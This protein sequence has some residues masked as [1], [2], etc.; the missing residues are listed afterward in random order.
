M[1]SQMN[2]EAGGVHVENEV[3]Q[4]TA[5]ADVVDLVA[6]PSG[7]AVYELVCRW[8]AATVF[9]YLDP[10]A[11]NPLLHDFAQAIDAV[12]FEYLRTDRAAVAE[13]DLLFD[14][15]A[16]LS[17]AAHAAEV[18]ACDQTT[19]FV[20]AQHLQEVVVLAVE[21]LIADTLSAAEV[22]ALAMALPTA[23]GA[24]AKDTVAAAVATGAD[25]AAHARDSGSMYRNDYVQ[26]GYVQDDYV[27]TTTTF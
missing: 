18:V 7:T 27:G 4:L 2:V 24:Q 5:R 16:R 12:V 20:D 13:R 19:G 10:R 21:K 23:D 8:I 3:R 26:F 1:P 17:D 6:D 14:I 11:M 15:G 22:V 25:E 9:G